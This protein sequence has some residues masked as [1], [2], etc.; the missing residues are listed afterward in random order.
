MKLALQLAYKNLIR[1]GLRTWLNVAVLS[2]AFVII[3]FFNAFMQGWNNQAKEDA[4]AW[5]FGQGHILN[6]KYDPYDA[7]TLQDGHNIIPKNIN[8]AT[9]ILIQQGSIYPEGRVVPVALKGIDIHQKTI[10]IPSKK[11]SDTTNQIPAIIGKR[12][13]ASTK[14][15]V[16][17]EVV[18]RW[19]DKNGTYDASKITV[20]AIFDSP[21][22]TIDNGQIWLPLDKL[23]KMTKL[24][25][26]ATMFVADKNYTKTNTD[27]WNFVSQKNLLKDIEAIIATESISSAIMYLVF[28]FI[29]LLAIFDTQVLA[30]FRRQKEIGTYI[31]LGMTRPKVVKLFTIEGTMHSFFAIIIGCIYGIPIFIFL[32]Q[33]GIAMPEFVGEMSIGIDKAVFPAYDPLII[34]LTVLFIIL[35]SAIVSYLPAKKIAKMS[36]V[37]ALKGKLQ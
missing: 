22:A 1:A 31:A 30:V 7:F 12:M 21:V 3:I 11:L 10:K 25:N 16:G 32:N 18:I 14:L 20:V 34:F 15:K 24:Q 6:N 19:R 8:N 37:L 9:P 26:Q 35:S 36:P 23:W 29:A 5:D 33:T 17:N 4:I 27:N 13:A 2:F 28:L